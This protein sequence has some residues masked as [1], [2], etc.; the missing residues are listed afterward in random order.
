MI[1]ELKAQEVAYQ[2]KLREKEID[3]YCQSNGITREQY[4][5]LR[6]LIKNLKRRKTGQDMEKYLLKLKKRKESLRGEEFNNDFTDD[7][8][9][10][11]KTL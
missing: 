7:I 1:N 9:D 6:F 2:S 5:A 4:T 11:L 10:A 3:E 8:I